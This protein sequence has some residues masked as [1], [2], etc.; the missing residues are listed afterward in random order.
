MQIT[1]QSAPLLFAGGDELGTRLLEFACQAL[2]IRG[3]PH[4]MRGYPSLSCQIREQSTI[5]RREGLTR[6]TWSKH[7]FTD[8]DALVAERQT[9]QL[10]LRRPVGSRNDQ[11]PILLQ[12]NG[13]I[14]EFQGLRYRLDNS[15]QHRLGR[16]GCFQA[17]P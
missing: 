8:Q 5:S 14:G 9:H 1:A 12:G 13:N 11:C 4:S 3:E 10:V 15:R 6:S 17:L 7:Q 2:Q 16:Q